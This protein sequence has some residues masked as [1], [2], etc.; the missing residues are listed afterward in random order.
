MI[1]P[2]NEERIL[3]E[4]GFWLHIMRD[5]ATFIAG[6]LPCDRPDLIERALA[7]RA[8]FDSLIVRVGADTAH[9]EFGPLVADVKETVRDFLAFKHF[10]LA[11][12]IQCQLDQGKNHNFALFL[13]HISREARE[14]LHLLDVMMSHLEPPFVTALRLEVFWLRIMK[15]HIEFIKH[16]LDPS[17]RTFA[18]KLRSSHKLFEGLLEEAR[19]L[20]SM[21]QAHPESFPVVARFT[22]EVIESTQGLRDFKA[23]AYELM[24]ECKLLILAPPELAEHVLEEA[25]HFLE[26]ITAIRKML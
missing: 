11:Q 1:N 12:V 13:D 3:D 26:A 4:I 25:E 7:F 15:E 6:N 20:A 24:K 14:F 16:L 10:L 22:D 5:H 2:P 21:L 9:V 23:T 18:A 8:L 19:D 17:E